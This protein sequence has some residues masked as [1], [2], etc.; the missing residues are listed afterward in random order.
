AGHGAAGDR[1]RY[2]E[3]RSAGEAPN[4]VRI[5]R[6]LFDDQGRPVPL[7]ARLGRGGE[8]SV[9]AVSAPGE[10]AAKVY[11]RPCPPEQAAKLAAMVALRNDRLLALAAWPVATL[12]A[13]AQ[14]PVQGFLMPRAA[15][16]AIHLLYGPK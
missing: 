12:R 2:P 5:D 8:G 11:P 6:N 4:C 16:R 7:G 14:G 15:G 1:L 10:L 13:G 9:F 3:E